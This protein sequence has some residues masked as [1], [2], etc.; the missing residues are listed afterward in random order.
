VWY[1]FNCFAGCPKIHWFDRTG[2]S[3]HNLPKP[4][5]TKSL[6]DSPLAIGTLSA[7]P[8][9]V[10]A[11]VFKNI[12]ANLARVAAIS[13][14]A[15]L[16]P[17]VLT[18]HLPVKVYAAWVLIIQLGAYVS[19]F[20]LGIQTGVAKFVAE[21]Q[22][23]GELSEAGRYASA[24]LVLMLLTGL[25]GVAL[26]LGLA[27]ET[28]RLFSSMP[29]NLFPQV[30]AGL[31]LVGVSLSVGL[32]C[33]VYSAVFLGLQRYW[34]PT[35]VTILNR[36]LFALVVLIAVVEGGNLSVMGLAV[37]LVNIFTGLLQ[38]A[39]WRRYASHV[40]LSARFV[41]FQILKNLARYCSLQSVSTIAMFFI[42]GLD[43]VI[44]GHFDYVQTA[45][46]SIAT[47]P[48]SFLLLI[49]ASLLSPLM[50]ASSALS[51]RLTPAQ[52]GGLLERITRYNT[53]A[54]LLA[55]LPLVVFAFPIL[56][57]WVGTDYALNTVTYLR[58]L[59]TANV[60]RNLCAPYATMVTATASQKSIIAAAIS[61]ALVN[62]GSSLYLAWRFGAI[63]V[64]IGTVLGACVSVFV[65]FAVSMTLSRSVISVS[66]LQL[67]LRGI[68]GPCIIAVPSLLLVPH[69]WSATNVHLISGLS[70]VWL[71]CTLAPAYYCLNRQERKNFSR[72]IVPLRRAR[73]ASLFSS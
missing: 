66:R 11:V 73:V 34:I 68:L 65:H 7:P 49:I 29:A 67:L 23:K 3:P 6:S 43:I 30:R 33:S 62:L 27:V 38:I 12:G 47:L 20:D 37:A 28:P 51:T 15:I 42:T 13:A 22:A 70:L 59:V 40:P 48:T 9:A 44:V 26:T 14:V 24:G 10:A 19:Y 52:M 46:Y 18:D 2:S 69:W 5:T 60:V 71:V 72:L 57:L 55:G 21:Y 35:F 16:L 36:F 61:E 41:P 56:W 45:Y 58:I 31:V 25:L 54:L 32:V 63:G 64:A 50:P 8:P 4:Y 17:S 53:I 39:L 1:L